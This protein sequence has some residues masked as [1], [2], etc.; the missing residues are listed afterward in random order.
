[1]MWLYLPLCAAWTLKKLICPSNSL[2][3]LWSAACSC[4]RVVSWPQVGQFFPGIRPVAFIVGSM[5]TSVVDVR[6]AVVV[7]VDIL[8][9]S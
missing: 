9:L 5:P 4:T 2:I 6:A 3:L 1:M 8:R 7:V